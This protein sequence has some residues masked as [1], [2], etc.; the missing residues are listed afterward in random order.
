MRRI[1]LHEIK[2]Q[3]YREKLASYLGYFSIISFQKPSRSN[4]W[5]FDSTIS[6]ELQR[7]N[8][9]EDNRNLPSGNHLRKLNT[10]SLPDPWAIVENTNGWFF[11]TC[12]D[13]CSVCFQI[14]FALDFDTWIIWFLQDNSHQTLNFLL[15]LKRKNI[16]LLQN[17]LLLFSISPI[18]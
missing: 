4:Y 8:I 17:S 16:K 2:F 10:I 5:D 13:F 14:H 15:Y 12:V 6:L 11:L 7:P 18:F 9:F 3:N 1:F